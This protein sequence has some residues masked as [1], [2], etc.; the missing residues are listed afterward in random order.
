M[1]A[2]G[3][4][5][6]AKA[7]DSR[8]ARSAKRTYVPIS[9]YDEQL[10]GASTRDKF[11]DMFYSSGPW[12]FRDDAF[13]ARVDKTADPP[14]ELNDRAT[15]SDAVE[16]ERKRVDARIQ[17][18]FDKIDASL[19]GDSIAAITEAFVLPPECRRTARENRRAA[20]ENRRLSAQTRGL[21]SAGDL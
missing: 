6:L 19:A 16:A 17:A 21:R 1:D 7:E 13:G 2:V 15:T 9:L 20:R 14:L 4:S 3:E 8:A 11:S 5:R 10:S 18:Q 12:H